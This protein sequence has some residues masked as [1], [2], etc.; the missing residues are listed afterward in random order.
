[1]LLPLILTILLPLANALPAPPQ[2]PP[3]PNFNLAD[4]SLL[5]TNL[6]GPS[7]APFAPKATFCYNENYTRSGPLSYTTCTQII[8]HKIATGPRPDL[9]HAF[10]R[11]PDPKRQSYVPKTWTDPSLQCGI[12]IDVP[13]AV[14]EMASLVE[15]Q[16]AARVIAIKCILG[17]QA[18]R[19]YRLGGFTFVGFHNELLVS[20]QGDDLF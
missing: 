20:V 13:G 14:V 19:D 5:P 6:T 9:W 15:I 7:N 1:M 11:R 16:A 12:R 4:L 2:T 10:A 8:E 18:P 3:R 17:G